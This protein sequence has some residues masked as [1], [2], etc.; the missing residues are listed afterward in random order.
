MPTITKRFDAVGIESSE[1]TRR[2]YRTLLF[3]TPGAGEYLA[4]VILFE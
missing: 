3:T 4:G 2:A 1:D